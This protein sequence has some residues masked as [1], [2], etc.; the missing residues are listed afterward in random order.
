MSGYEQQ[1]PLKM[2]VDDDDDYNN[3]DAV[4]GQHPPGRDINSIPDPDDPEAR[5]E[6]LRQE[7]AGVNQI[8]SVIEGVITSLDK[9]R[10]NMTV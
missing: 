6:A 10:E 8:N 3:N 4:H 5:E 9:A 2:E 1:I 7:L